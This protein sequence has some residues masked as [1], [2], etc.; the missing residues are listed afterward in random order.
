MKISF[1]L[2]FLLSFLTFPAISN[3]WNWEYDLWVK[4]F[5]RRNDVCPRLVLAVIEV[6]SNFR[7]SSVSPAGAVGF[8]QLMPSTALMLGIADP[9]DPIENLRGGIKYLGILKKQFDRNIPM[10]LAA[11]NAGPTAVR[12]YGSIPPFKETHNFVFRVLDRYEYYNREGTGSAI[13][14]ITP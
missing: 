7:H 5:S 14:S 6:E 8:M 13:F 3:D 12:R 11:Y 2:I 10:A 4:E 1:I 9:S